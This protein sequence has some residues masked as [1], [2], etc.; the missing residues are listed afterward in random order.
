MSEW[1]EEVYKNNLLAFFFLIFL[2]FFFLFFLPFS[3]S[4]IL[5]TNFLKTQICVRIE[6]LKVSPL[7]IFIS[8]IVLYDILVEHL[9]HYTWLGYIKN[10]IKDLSHGFLSSRWLVHNQFINLKQSIRCCSALPLNWRDD[11][12]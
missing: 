12:F 1:Y 2:Y 9:L 5:L 7:F 4:Y 11:W 6:S 10:Y 8:C 3:F